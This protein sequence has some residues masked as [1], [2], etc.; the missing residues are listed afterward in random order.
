[1][2]HI[3]ILPPPSLAQAIHN[4]CTP[5]PCTGNTKRLHQV[6][7]LAQGGVL[8]QGAFMNVHH[9]TLLNAFARTRV[10]W[11]ASAP[12]EIGSV[13]QAPFPNPPPPKRGLSD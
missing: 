1:M 8:A 3:I 9:T 12:W 13:T 7:V 11:G 4:N 5:P 10:F 2:G 6:V